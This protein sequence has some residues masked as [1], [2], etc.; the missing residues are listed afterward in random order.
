MKRDFLY[1]LR[2]IG[3]I[4]ANLRADKLR[5]LGNLSMS[6]VDCY[7]KVYFEKEKKSKKELQ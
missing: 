5:N 4:S 3:T 6:K 1:P 2:E 7:K